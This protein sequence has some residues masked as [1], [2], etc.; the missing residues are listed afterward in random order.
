[1]TTVFGRLS[2]AFVG[3][4]NFELWPELADLDPEEV[5]NGMADGLFG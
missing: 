5:A 1:M 4:H 2:P 3:Q